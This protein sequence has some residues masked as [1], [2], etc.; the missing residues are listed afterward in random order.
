[1]E[2]SGD[3][4]LTFNI[5]TMNPEEMVCLN[6]VGQ[7]TRVGDSRQGKEEGTCQKEGHSS[8]FLECYEATGKP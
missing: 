3:I 7:C 8:V 1:M 6:E 2:T 5:Y 4:K